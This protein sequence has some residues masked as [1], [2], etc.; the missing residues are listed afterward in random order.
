MGKKRGR[1]PS[2][3][4]VAAKSALQKKKHWLDC[5]NE[6]CGTGDGAYVDGDVVGFTCGS[7]VALTV[8]AP[9]QPKPALTYAEKQERK[10]ARAERK[11]VR[12][13]AKVNRESLGLGRGWHKRILFKT[14]KD[15]KQLY[16]SRGKKITAAKYKALE[17]KVAKTAKAK[18]AKPSFGR[19]WHFKK[20]FVGPDGSVYE[21]GKLLHPGL[22]RPDLA[23]FELLMEQHKNG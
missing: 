5:D 22:E 7:C 17:K 18:D 11:K 16:F 8:A 4:T 21:S 2:K 1:K 12:D 13:A 15:G 19:G 23:E 9:E 10:A 6:D 20:T 14:E 3:K